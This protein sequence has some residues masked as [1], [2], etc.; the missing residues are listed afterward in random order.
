MPSDIA[1]VTRRLRYEL[2]TGQYAPGDRVWGFGELIDSYGLANPA[3][4]GRALAPLIAEGWLVS[5]QG[6][7]TFVVEVPTEAG[8]NPD[9]LDLI[10]DLTADLKAATLKLARVQ[11]VLAG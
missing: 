7:G 10:D 6:S 3:A 11:E 5:K 8:T 4:C 9:V 2:A 1:R